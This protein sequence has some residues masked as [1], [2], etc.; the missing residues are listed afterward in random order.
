MT[1]KTLRNISL[2]PWQ[3]G[4]ITDAALVIL[5]IDHARTTRPQPIV[6]TLLGM[7][8]LALIHNAYANV[9]RR[10]L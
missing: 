7:A 2:D 5:H 4:K 6:R 10:A 8:S 3:I 9:D 1:F